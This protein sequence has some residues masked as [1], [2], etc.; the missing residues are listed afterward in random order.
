MVSFRLASQHEENTRVF[1]TPLLLPSA[2][3]GR[4][5]IALPGPDMP[6]VIFF[7]HCSGP[8][9]IKI[10]PKKAEEAQLNTCLETQ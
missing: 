6:A 7:V 1:N 5:C 3:A 2:A 8:A 4:L 10:V 9:L